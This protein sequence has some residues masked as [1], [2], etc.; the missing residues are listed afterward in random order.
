MFCPGHPIS[1]EGY[2]ICSR[3]SNGF[4]PHGRIADKLTQQQQQAQNFKSGGSLQFCLF[5]MLH[6]TIRQCYN[7]KIVT[8]LQQQQQAQNVTILRAEEVYNSISQSF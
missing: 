7:V 5:L 4:P 2:K 1:G 6:V 3:A 8:M